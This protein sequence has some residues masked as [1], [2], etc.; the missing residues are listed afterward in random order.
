M[1]LIKIYQW[2]KVENSNNK[3][4]DKIY[5]VNDIYSTTNKKFDPNKQFLGKWIRLPNIDKK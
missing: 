5:K 3:L 4:L 1:K 2:V